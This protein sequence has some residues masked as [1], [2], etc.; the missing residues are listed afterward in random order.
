M[1]VPTAL[2]EVLIAEILNVVRTKF[3]LDEA[4]NIEVNSVEVDQDEHKI[5]IDILIILL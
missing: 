3:N 4:S 1:A 5:R 2:D